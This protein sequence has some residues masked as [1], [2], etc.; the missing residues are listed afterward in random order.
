MRLNWAYTNVLSQLARNSDSREGPNWWSRNKEGDCRGD[1]EGWA[2][3]VEA[4]DFREEGP[5]GWGKFEEEYDSE[6]TAADDGEIDPKSQ[7]SQL[8]PFDTIFLYN[9]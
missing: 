9:R 7:Q 8:L 6:G 4:S 2:E 1:E 5:V 3:P